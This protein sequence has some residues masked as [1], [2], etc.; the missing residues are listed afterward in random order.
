MA[1]RAAVAQQP[2]THGRMHRL[3]SRPVELA[4]E[5]HAQGRADSGGHRRRHCLRIDQKDHGGLLEASPE[6]RTQH[7]GAGF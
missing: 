3:R 4:A 1:G 6:Q 7:S 2:H 5:R